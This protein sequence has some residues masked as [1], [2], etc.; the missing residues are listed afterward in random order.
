MENI[1]NINHSLYVNADV[2]R[3]AKRKAPSQVEQQQENT[4]QHRKHIIKLGSQQA[5]SDAEAIFS[6]ANSYADVS[7]KVQKSLQAYEAVEVSLKREAVSQ[8]MGIDLYA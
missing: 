6:R 4:E 5:F 7:S 1:S 2:N 8:L 3:D